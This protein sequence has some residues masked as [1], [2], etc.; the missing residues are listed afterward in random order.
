MYGYPRYRSIADRWLP[1][2]TAV[3]QQG[4]DRGYLA[5]TFHLYRLAR[6]TVPAVPA[7]RR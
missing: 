6:P 1:A 2:T 3:T 5:S 4:E 7:A